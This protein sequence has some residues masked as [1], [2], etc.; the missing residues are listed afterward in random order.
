MKEFTMD[1]VHEGFKEITDKEF[2]S[3]CVVGSVFISIN[4]KNKLCGKKYIIT[5]IDA[6]IISFE[7]TP[8]KN[9]K[10]IALKSTILEWLYELKVEWV[11]K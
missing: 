2:D 3:L 11:T 9:I 7:S 10:D 4:K 5:A 8:E 6:D 1:D